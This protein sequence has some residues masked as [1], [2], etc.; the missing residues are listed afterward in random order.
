MT[1]VDARE[2]DESSRCL[3]PGCESGTLVCRG[4]ASRQVIYRAH[5]TDG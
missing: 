3:P 5:Q 4:R 1:I 2:V